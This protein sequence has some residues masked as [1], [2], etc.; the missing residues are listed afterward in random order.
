MALH[1]KLT[2]Y[3][4]GSPHYHPERVQMRP[5]H[6][7]R[8]LEH[9]GH[10]LCFIEEGSARAR[11]GMMFETVMLCPR[12]LERLPQSKGRADSVVADFL[13]RPESARHKV[14]AVLTP[15][16]FGVADGLHQVAP[17]VAEEDDE[18]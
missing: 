9:A 10:R 7:A 15:Q 1:F 3:G 11:P 18:A 16:D 12:H 5:L 14:K 6:R 17:L 4:L 13:F 8:H 2:P